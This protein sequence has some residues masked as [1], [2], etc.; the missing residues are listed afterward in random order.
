MA[1]A[2]PSPASLN[3]TWL[4][5]WALARIGYKA[6]WLVGRYGYLPDDRKDLEQELSLRLLERLKDQDPRQKDRRLFV[7]TALDS[8]LKDLIRHQQTQKRAF[9]R[10]AGSLDDL[11]DGEDG[12]QVPR[13]EMLSQ[14]DLLS[15]LQQ[16]AADP[17]EK[18]ELALDVRTAIQTLPARLGKIAQDLL[19]GSYDHVPHSVA[20]EDLL[21][22][23]EH[24]RQLGLGD[25]LGG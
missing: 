5:D 22:I 17:T 24:F 2:P 16:G 12:Q 21:T 9:F 8:A 11:V 1:T 23:R 19:D 15:R 10:S 4:D 20:D 18:I 6:R 7:L 3:E 14:D 25:Y 13:S